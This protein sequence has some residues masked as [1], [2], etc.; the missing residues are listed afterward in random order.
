MMISQPSASTAGS[1]FANSHDEGCSVKAS[2]SLAAHKRR[3]EAGASSAWGTHGAALQ[4]KGVLWIS[5]IPLIY[6]TYPLGSVCQSVNI[7]RLP[8][9]PG[10]YH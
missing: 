7:R 5:P 1:G 3:R 10:E 6:S 8:D 4:K 9:K 2:N